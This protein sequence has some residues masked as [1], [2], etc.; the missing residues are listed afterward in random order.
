MH[1]IH[2]HSSR[3]NQ[4]RS[5]HEVGSKQAL[6]ALLLFNCEDGTIYSSEILVNF[7]WTTWHHIPDDSTLDSE[8]FAI[9]IHWRPVATIF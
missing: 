6:L 8:L 3:V 7:Y 2:L 1:H 4:G 5:Q 9:Q